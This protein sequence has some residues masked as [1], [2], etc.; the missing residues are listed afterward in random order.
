MKEN[1]REIL[2]KKAYEMGA[3]CTRNYKGCSKCVVATVQDIMG[4][5]DDVVLKVATGLAGGIGL[6]GIGPCGGISGGILV[7]SQLVG[8]ERSNIED[9]GDIK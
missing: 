6:S 4:I 9:P 7:L 8:R 1:R 3:E 5:R 2:L